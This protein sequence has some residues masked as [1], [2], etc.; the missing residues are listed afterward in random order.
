MTK[1]E[2]TQLIGT[3]IIIIATGI[4]EFSVLEVSPSGLYVKLLNENGRKIWKTTAEL[5]SRAHVGLVERLPVAPRP[6]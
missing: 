6:R 2:I 5:R 1:E 3:R 4:E